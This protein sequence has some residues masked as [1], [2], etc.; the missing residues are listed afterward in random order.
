MAFDLV[1]KIKIKDD[2]ASKTLNK[3]T[4]SVGRAEKLTSSLTRSTDRLKTSQSRATSNSER[5]KTVLKGVGSSANFAGNQMRSASRGT[6]S[7][8]RGVGGLAAAYVGAKTA[9]GLFN[10]TIGAAADYEVKQVTVNAMFGKSAKTNAQKYLDFVQSRAAVSMFSA[11]DYLTA[12]K[13]FIPT[14]KDNAK[15]QK[16]VNL[17]E[18][19]GAIDPEQGITGAAY[20]LK[21]FFSGDAVSLVERFELPRKAM[22]DIKNLP[23]DKQLKAL[24]KFLNGIGATNDLIDAQAGTTLGQYK[25]AIGQVNRAFREMGTQALAKINHLL[26]DFNK[27]LSSADFKN[28]KKWGVDAFSG[29]VSGA[30]NAVRKAS[31]Y[32]NTKFIKNPAFQNL[33]DVKSKIK[34]IFNSL[35]EDF[36]V[37]YK[38]DGKAKIEEIAKKTVDTLGGAMEA[39]QPLIDA[40]VKVGT[41]IG[42]GLL[43]GIMSDPTLALILGGGV[44]AK[45]LGKLGG[46]KGGTTLTKTA[47]GSALRN[48]YVLGGT[49]L[50]L[51]AGAEASVWENVKNDSNSIYS[52]KA[53]GGGTQ[54]GKMIGPTPPPKKITDSQASCLADYFTGKGHAGGLDRVP[55]NGYQAR[56]HKDET[57]LTKTEASRYREDQ[58]SDGG[59]PF[60]INM[61]GTVIREDADVER[62]AGTLARRLAM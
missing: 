18:R 24:D 13:S 54:T 8:V 38:S 27:Y 12:G 14:T 59:K 36:N 10:K 15:L 43:Q 42:S 34:F 41:S 61:Y 3:V 50:A 48:P 37:W 9:A 45:L 19:L 21:E 7:L 6:A 60:V 11:D 62:L 28:I 51:A 49:A 31:D 57:V 52:S 20:A 39:S 33:P 32:I 16:M 46:G 2:G 25:K 55:Y 40:A 22:N 58:H 56:L 44:G 1:G 53:L 23:L 29:L 35:M 4:D 26:K 30:T 17:S 47:G 5:L